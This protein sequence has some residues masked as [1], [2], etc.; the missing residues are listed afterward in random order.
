[1][2]AINKLR[3][4]MKQLENDKSAC[5]IALYLIGRC[6]ESESLCQDVLNDKKT[7]HGCMDYVKNKA[8]AQAVNGC[9]CIEDDTVFEWAED[10]YHTEIKDAPEPKKAATKA[11]KKKSAPKEKPDLIKAI[12][13]VYGNR[14]EDN[15]N[16]Q[17][18]M[19]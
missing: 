4:E 11:P 1:M 18:S 10:Y 3:N 19:F 14:S 17:I 7:L 13:E 5:R 9:A 8:R 6:G 15:I 16:G 12:N 2:E